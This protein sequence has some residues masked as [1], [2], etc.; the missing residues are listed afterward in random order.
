MRIWNDYMPIMLVSY[1][2]KDTDEKK[3]QTITTIRYASKRS[4][5]INF[6]DKLGILDAFGEEIIKEVA[7]NLN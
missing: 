7:N 6:L 3:Q 5:Y 2:H 4:A 1:E